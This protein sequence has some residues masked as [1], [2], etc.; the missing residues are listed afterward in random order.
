MKAKAPDLVEELSRVCSRVSI[1]H[2]DKY[3][4]LDEILCQIENGS[5][6]VRK[7]FETVVEYNKKWRKATGSFSTG[8][9]KIVKIVGDEKP[10]VEIFFHEGESMPLHVEVT[11]PN[12][13]ENIATSAS[14]VFPKTWFCLERKNELQCFK[15]LANADDVENGYYIAEFASKLR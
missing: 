11:V 10:V 4:S 2:P 14:K 8:E 12:L 5:K 3:P 6:T 15:P 1:V 13:P 7:V 9:P